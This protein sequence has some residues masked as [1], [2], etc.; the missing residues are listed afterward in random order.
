[1]ISNCCG[2]SPKDDMYYDTCPKCGEP[3]EFIEEEE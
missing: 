3:C 2:A 1:M